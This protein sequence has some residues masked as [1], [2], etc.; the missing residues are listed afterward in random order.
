MNDGWVC[1]HYV[2]YM[3]THTQNMSRCGGERTE[4]NSTLKLGGKNAWPG[5][6]LSQEI[7]YRGTNTRLE[8]FGHIFTAV[9]VV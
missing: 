3:S 5:A 9:V 4:E 2:C 1:V 6:R 7:T 8:V